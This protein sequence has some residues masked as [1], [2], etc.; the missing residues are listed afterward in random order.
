[1]VPIPFVW[2]LI[3]FFRALWQSLKDPEFQALFLLVVTMLA[4]GAL[5][6]RQVEGWSLL[7]SLY[8][9]VITLTTVGYG[10]FSPSTT[11]GKIFTM[12]Y[13]FVGI[14]I[15]LGFVNAVAERSMEQRGGIRG[16]LNRRGKGEGSE[17]EED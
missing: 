7:D 6:Y 2:V 15:I 17:G 8:F 5:F 16:L 11:A 10:D 9:S 13:I 1:M 12:F 3:R 14:G 4:S